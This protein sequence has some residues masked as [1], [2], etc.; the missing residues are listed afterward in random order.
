MS[1]FADSVRCWLEADEE[2]IIVVHCKGIFNMKRTH[3]TGE[4]IELNLNG[5]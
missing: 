3:N 4:L 5:T 1:D 2:N